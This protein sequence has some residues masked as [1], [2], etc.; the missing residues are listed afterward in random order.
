M[1]SVNG[2]EHSVSAL[3][4]PGIDLSTVENRNNLLARLRE[5]FDLADIKWLVKATANGKHGRR[6]LMVPYADPRTYGRRLND[7]VTELGWTK[8]Y[9]LQV[10]EGFH[11]RQRQMKD[12]GAVAGAKVLV[13]CKL[14]I[15][16][17]GTHSG[18]GEAWADD[19]NVLT[20]ADA[21]AFKRACSDFGVGR[22]LYDLEGQWVDL[23]DRD[24]PLTIP[25][26]P[27]WAVPK[28]RKVR[29]ES[30]AGGTSA[31]KPQAGKD[32]AIPEDQKLMNEIVALASEVGNRLAL[33]VVYEVRKI[34]PPDPAKYTFKPIGELLSKVSLADLRSVRKRLQDVKAEVDRLKSAIGATGRDVY[35]RVCTQLNYPGGIIDIPNPQILADLVGR[36]EVLAKEASP[37]TS[38]RAEPRERNTQNG[39][40]KASATLTDLK[41]KL[42]ALARDLASTTGES[43]NSLI[44]WASDGKFQFRDVGRLAEAK[45]LR[46]AVE[47]LTERQSQRP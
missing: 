11:R 24:Q 14:T 4:A 25:A 44:L 28:G 47:K 33:S 21:Q 43:I 15:Y 7:V 34:H 40:G 8:E 23:D 5:P 37:T 12:D 39:N 2:V 20:S 35:A 19:E 32:A 10:V 42:L 17:L 18:T 3:S 46:Q 41:N 30:P 9:S 22:Y 26:V 1:A 45:S 16:G 27:L 38:H 31:M 36:M 13:I 29:R 6:G